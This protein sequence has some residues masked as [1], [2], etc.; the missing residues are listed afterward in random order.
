MRSLRRQLK[1]ELMLLRYFSNGSLRFMPVRECANLTRSS[2]SVMSSVPTIEL[3]QQLN[4]VN[5]TTNTNENF[6]Y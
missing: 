6:K 5:Y 2:R 4:C 3:Y 1:P